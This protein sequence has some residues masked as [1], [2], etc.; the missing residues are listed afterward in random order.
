MP[1]VGVVNK[2]ASSESDD[3][4]DD[5]ELKAASG[6]GKAEKSK[7]T[8]S[9][10]RYMAMIEGLKDLD[11]VEVEASSDPKQSTK[12][13]PKLDTFENFMAQMDQE[14]RKEVEEKELR[15]QARGGP[16][17]TS[18]GPFP[19]HQQQETEVDDDEDDDDSDF[20]GID[21]EMRDELNQLMAG[22]DE[23]GQEELI[24][25][26]LQTLRANGGGMGPFNSLVGR[27]G[28]DEDWR[29]Y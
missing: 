11:D 16:L 9:S 27:L 1:P 14:L 15:K 24:D 4:N 6:S 25:N 8:Y 29:H 13:N 12:R 3:D 7:P 28:D 23:A 2:K 17:S 22:S 10:D 20:G 5:D 21:A 19:E 26:L 18:M